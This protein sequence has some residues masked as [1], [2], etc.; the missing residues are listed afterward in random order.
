MKFKKKK[1]ESEKDVENSRRKTYIE[2]LL[3]NADLSAM[4]TISSSFIWFYY[5]DVGNTLGM[6]L[7]P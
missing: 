3:N 1:P 6:Q 2:L 4:S 7:V 5:H